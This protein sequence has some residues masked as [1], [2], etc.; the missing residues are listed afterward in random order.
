MMIPPETARSLEPFSGAP[1]LPTFFQNTTFAY[2]Q[3]DWLAEHILPVITAMKPT[4][5]RPAFGAPLLGAPEGATSVMNM[6]ELVLPAER[7]LDVAAF[8]LN[9]EKM[10]HLSPQTADGGLV[11]AL[12]ELAGDIGGAPIT[13]NALILRLQAFIQN[14]TAQR[15]T[16]VGTERE[17]DND[18]Q[19]DLIIFAHNL[20]KPLMGDL[21][22]LKMMWAAFRA[23]DPHGF[24]FDNPPLPAE[25]PPA[26]LPP[27]LGA[28][29]EIPDPD[30]VEERELVGATRTR[31]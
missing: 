22:S 7:V 27:V 8:V 6:P 13:D 26:P 10:A 12:T 14:L 24:G 23:I 3:G 19:A 4:G 28:T 9:S 31:R 2:Q 17:Y 16:I 29:A 11:T 15:D 5:T 1:T 25:L 18:Q 20:A 21:L 30:E